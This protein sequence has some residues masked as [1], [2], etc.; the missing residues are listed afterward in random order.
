MIHRLFICLMALF[1]VFASAC[2]G[3]GGGSPDTISEIAE[4]AGGETTPEVSIQEFCAEHPGEPCEDND[5]CTKGM[6]ICI[7]SGETATCFYEQSAHYECNTGSD[8]CHTVGVCDGNGGCEYDLADGWCFIG[9]ECIADGTKKPGEPCQAC[10]SE[11][12]RGGWSPLTGT[13]CVP[14]DNE[15]T[16][17]GKCQ[18]GFCVPQ[19]GNQE[20]AADYDC[21][22]KDDGDLC[23]GIYKCEMCKCAFD[24][25]SMVT[26]DTST[27]SAC[28]VTSC[29]PDTGECVQQAAQ[30]GTGCDDGDPC[31]SGDYCQASECISGEKAELVWGPIASPDTAYVSSVEVLS[32][33]SPAIY[34]VGT[35]GVFYRT[36]K[37]SEPFETSD[38]VA[39]GGAVGD[40]LLVVPGE[41]ASILAIFDGQLIASVDGG[42]SYAP[43]LSDCEALARTGSTPT[44]LVAAC[45]DQLYKSADLGA[46]WTLSGSVPAGG[47]PDITALA[48]FNEQMLLA[49]TRGED[50]AGRG[51]VYKSDNGGASWNPVDPPGRPDLAYVSPHGLLIS[52]NSPDKAFLGYS[53]AEGESFEFG[54]TALFRSDDQGQ[55]FVVLGTTALG[56]IYTPLSLDT[57]G[58]LLVGV[59]KVLHRGGQFGVGPWGPIKVPDTLAGVELHTVADAASQPGSNFSFLVPASNGLAVA[60]DLGAS[61]ELY[62]SGMRAGVFAFVETCGQNMF[63][64]DHS[65]NGLY[66]STDGG[67]IWLEVELPDEAGA[68]VIDA[69]T[70][71][72][73]DPARVLAFTLSGGILTSSDAGL[74]FTF[75]DETNGPTLGTITGLT[76][77]RDN[78]SRI[79][80]SRLGMGLFVSEDGAFSEGKGFDA[81]PVPNTF[82]AS[83][84]ADPHDANFVYVGTYASKEYG[85]A[86]IYRCTEGGASC[87]VKLQ[88]DMEPVQGQRTGFKLYVNRGM[89]GRVYGAIGGKGAAIYYSSDFGESW[90]MFVHLPVQGTLGNG[91][92][93]PDRDNP[94]SLFVAYR[95]HPLVRYSQADNEWSVLTEAPFSVSSLAW[96]PGENGKLL[97]ASGVDSKIWGS[98]D[99]G[100]S[101]SLFKDFT[102]SG[103]YIHR[104]VSDSGYLFAVLYGKLQGQG[105]LFVQ[106]GIQWVDC[107]IDEPVTDVVVQIPENE[108]VIATARLGGLYISDDGGASFV[109]MEGLDTAV[110]DLLVASN[111]F[112]RIY[113]A[114][115]CG[116]LPAWYDET[117]PFLGPDCGVM[118]S[119]DGGQFWVVVWNSS[120]KECTSI[121]DIPENPEMLVAACPDHGVVVTTNGGSNWDKLSDISGANAEL[122]KRLKGTNSL[123]FRDGWL[124]MGTHD[125]GVLRAELSFENWSFQNFDSQFSVGAS[126][127]FTVSGIQVAPDPQ[128]AS[129]VVIQATPGGLARTEDH[130]TVWRSAMGG[131]VPEM[132]YVSGEQFTPALLPIYVPAEAGGYELWAGSAGQ[133]YFR[134]G[135][136]GRHWV[137]GSLS[138]PALTKAHPVAIAYDDDYAGYVWYGAREGVF[139]T[140][141]FGLTWSKVE[142]GLASGI[143][144][145]LLG[146]GNGQV[147]AAITGAGLFRVPFDGGAWQKAHDLGFG[148]MVAPAW[149]GRRFAIWHSIAGLSGSSQ[150]F[151]LALDPHGLYLTQDGGLSFKQA[152]LTLPLGTMSGLTVS[153]HDEDTLFLGTAEGPYISHDSGST[154]EPAGS[155]AGA[156]GRCYDFAFDHEQ[157][158]LVYALCANGLPHGKPAPGEAETAS[159]LVRSVY[160]SDDGGETWTKIAAGLSPSKVPV[161]IVADP[162]VSGIVYLVNAAGAVSRSTDFGAVFEPWG[163]GLPSP[164]TAG[165][166]RLY[167][168]P[169]A[170][171]P[172]ADRFLIGTDGFGF[173]A[174]TLAAA[175]N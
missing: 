87:S 53:N 77:D 149:N 64:V 111:D 47:G 128:N 22:S 12:N 25:A 18:E 31:T 99:G 88:S 103:Y 9:K 116:G 127:L 32:G 60:K 169:V 36:T 151:L 120:S 147:Y 148:D 16:A 21:L 101:W 91:D 160:R 108:Q 43:K 56:Q 5:P 168:S 157:D 107:G 92:V 45:Q 85:K 75:A 144:E 162:L 155:G 28:I 52:A 154:F 10:V 146:P 82:I 38:I 67:S 110:N 35:G 3:G 113:A 132:S 69:L 83:V 86:R 58:Q 100:E 84:V 4:T 163:T 125:S 40:W 13:T 71:S 152:G 142:T 109:A 135:D 79:Y 161:Q 7:G 98:S 159:S 137:Y 54:S 59:D 119:I 19:A 39:P 68:P 104:L 140:S 124:Y 121:V 173:Y 78:P 74:T 44:I 27:D 126:N 34:A 174:R 48:A 139:R 49:G 6:G 102:L 14:E 138:L 23:N 55:T 134:S 94:G 114:V 29:I 90:Q 115:S 2:G 70:C 89:E 175:C 62:K 106:E 61:W 105:K 95:E 24:V 130:G 145:A 141:D 57:M 17:S 30:D 166:N 37:L 80:M 51:Y 156:L 1:L 165:A 8:K 65:S 171:S 72:P 15:C 122:D 93:L 33:A 123:A 117:E 112:E 11:E 129:R 143:V 172:S 170:A 73:A 167:S 153:P 50:G 96:A 26:C 76:A 133:G 81:L 131:M 97:A 118:R 150:S 42:L 136:H 20:C 164:R 66:R 63:G 41:P 46:S 158:S